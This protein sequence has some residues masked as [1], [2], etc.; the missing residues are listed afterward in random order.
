MS[1]RVV[2]NEATSF[3]IRRILEERNITPKMVQK[4]LKLNSVQAVYKWINPKNKAIP[5]LDN[6]VQLANYLNCGIEEIL[7]MKEIDVED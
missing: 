3:N 1:I 4:T 6:L 5:S 2:D 7:V